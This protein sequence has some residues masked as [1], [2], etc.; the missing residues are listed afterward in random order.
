MVGG[1]LG[2]VGVF[3]GSEDA[4]GAEESDTIKFYCWGKVAEL[5]WAFLFVISDRRTKVG[6]RWVDAAG[7]VVIQC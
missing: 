1:R 6:L 3:L 5:V 4:E 2:M 7:E